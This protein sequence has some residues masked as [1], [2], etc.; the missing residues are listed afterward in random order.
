MTDRTPRLSVVLPTP[1]DFASIAATVRHLVRQTIARDIELVI[2]AMGRTDMAI[3]REACRGL[4][5]TRVVTSGRRSHGE[6]CAAGVRAA[7]G[8]VVVFAEDH[9]FPEPRWAE[10]LLAGYSAE[11]IAAVGPVFRNAN[12]GTMVSWC[13][14]AIGY[15]P[16]IDPVPGG[17]QPFI[18]GHNSSYRRE[19]LVALDDRLEDLLE[20]ETVLHFEL[21]ASGRRVVVEPAARAA[22]VNFAR[23]GLWIPVQFHS[24]RVFAAERA[25]GWGRGRRLFYGCASPLIPLVR[26]ARAIG[27]LRRPG[28]VRPGLAR[29]VPLLLVGLT[30]D[31]VGQ[32][33]GYLAGA[34][35]SPRFLT[36]F[37]FGRVNFVPAEE[38]ALWA[39]Q[40]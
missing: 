21:R 8:P 14:F 3:D 34:G 9:C 13:D 15:G 7:R 37:E 40:P 27:H 2:V 24:G 17:D 30:A 31:G 26:C 20:S 18:A 5:D 12:P 35:G 39:E 28:L 6:A 29:L 38:R 25:R 36:G 23:L 16:W 11:S 33:V 32:L 10:S 22:H 1:F 19:V 4:G